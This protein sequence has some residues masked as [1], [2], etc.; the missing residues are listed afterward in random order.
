M[1]P[2]WSIALMG[3]TMA[4]AF[5]AEE[6]IARN[7]ATPYVIAVSDQAT[8]PERTAA[9]ELRTFLGRMTG[10][11]F[12]IMQES[13][14]DAATP[15]FLVGSSDRS[16]AALSGV[17][18]SALGPDGIV[19]QTTGRDVVL[20][21]SPPRGP[22]YAV[23]TF[24]EDIC[25]CRWWTSTESSIPT[26]P[27][28]TIPAL[29]RVYTPALRY[30]EAFYRDA[31]NSPFAARLKLNG[32]FERIPPEYGGH[33]RIIGWCHTFF[34]FLP[35]KTYF[36]A[37][38]EWYSEIDGKRRAGH[39]QLCLT[40]PEMRAEFVRVVRERIR[41]HPDAGILSVSQ[42]DWG[43]RCQ[44]PACRA[45]EEREGSPSGPLLYFV[46]AVAA[47]LEKEFPDLLVETLA[48]QYTR[49]PPKTIRPRHNV[50]VRLC[51]IEC[52]YAQPL[53]T[54]KQNRSFRNDINA[55]SAVAPK[56]YI[57]NY[58]TNFHN[59][60]LPHPN[61]RV[62]G[63]NIRTFV[64]H[65]AI[66]LFEQGD[67][68]CA[69]GDF[70]RLRAWLLAHL[71]WN[72]DAD[73]SALIDTFL[74]GYYGPAAP[75]LRR[76]LDTLHDA[77]EASGV[78]L[79][80][81]MEDTSKWLSPKVL[82]Q[83]EG[84]Y[85]QALAAV[86]DDP[87]LWRRVRRERLPLDHVRLQQWSRDHTAGGSDKPG[88]SDWDKACK[89]CEDFIALCKEH[90][91]GSYREGHPFAEFETRLRNR[92]RPPGPPPKR[93]AGL[94]PSDWRDFQDNTFTLFGF[95]K[96]SRY[97]DDPQASDGKAVLMPGNHFEWAVQCPLR[98]DMAAAGPWRVFVSVRCTATVPEGPA[99]SLGVYD[100]KAG[101]DLARKTIPVSALRGDGYH[102]IEL[103]PIAVRDG[104]YVWVAPPKR[105]G[106]VRSVQVDRITLIREAA[107]QR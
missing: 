61:L 54:G 45:L 89:A 10:A 7:G 42:N 38:P 4:A 86:A 51:S 17:D 43:G 70:V 65:H 104:V 80:C 58:V 98:D 60:I 73:E 14:V 20:S 9:E 2:T 40:N 48:Y 29:H 34:Q 102:T 11:E 76:Y 107:L 106:K 81:Y 71:M 53:E 75:Y 35:P 59:Y 19:M 91:A 37:H 12:P 49:K 95:G 103:G 28:L 50:V 69:V 41:Q 68:G 96:L 3:I 94:P 46:N 88:S 101:K 62:L 72:P 25:G 5:G 27:V 84:I 31:F 100:A 33:Y 26:T 90:H 77:A 24:L 44:C 105:P 39:S 52:S 23:Y 18:L 64:Q 55:W 36:A 21:G 66:G 97:V 79:R 32:H 6:E 87:A 30:R 1:A 92:F 16:Q 22:L 85:D 93:C 57:W 67:A 83:A 15:C 82:R 78:Y 8:A 99:L 74:A 56:L 13:N 47:E 63:P